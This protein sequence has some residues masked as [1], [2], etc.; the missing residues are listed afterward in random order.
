MGPSVGV[1]NAKL[2]SVTYWPS[3][4]MPDF[5]LTVDDYTDQTP[6]HFTASVHLRL[7]SS[8]LH[9]SPVPVLDGAALSS[10]QGDD[11]LSS[12][13]KKME[14]PIPVGISRIR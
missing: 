5:Q 13:G 12:E 4:L 10:P 3:L 7:F 14:Q 6:S 1:A 8:T 9:F 11:C 2:V